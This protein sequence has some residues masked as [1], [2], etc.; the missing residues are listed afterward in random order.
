MKIL[1]LYEHFFSHLPVS[2]VQKNVNKI[3]RRQNIS[4]CHP[5]DLKRIFNIFRADANKCMFCFIIKID[6]IRKFHS[7]VARVVLGKITSNRFAA[8]N[9]TKADA[10]I[11][12]VRE[13]SIVDKLLCTFHSY[14]SSYVILVN[15]TATNFQKI[16]FMEKHIDCY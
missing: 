7:P 3:D 13:T 9:A 11:N 5:L 14:S 16:I 10:C 1:Q 8:H 6:R 4:Y 15:E 2:L 12:F